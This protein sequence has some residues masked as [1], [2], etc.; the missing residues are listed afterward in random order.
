MTTR[1][2]FLFLANNAIVPPQPN[3]SSSGWGVTIITVLFVQLSILSW[4]VA[5]FAAKTRPRNKNEP[6]SGDFIILKPAVQNRGD[7]ETRRETGIKRN[8][9]PFFLSPKR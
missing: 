4:A 6:R 1:I 7:A 2:R 8:V 5:L 3:K 9:L